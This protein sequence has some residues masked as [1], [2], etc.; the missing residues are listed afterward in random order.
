MN[1]DKKIDFD[2]IKNLDGIIFL[3]DFFDSPHDWG[4]LA[5]DDFYKWTIY[6][7]YLIQKY[8]LR[9]GVKPHPNSWHNSLDSVLI[10]Q[11]LKKKF[12]KIIWLD[13][14]YPNKA[15]F[16]NI[17]FGISCT[18]TVLFELA[19]HNIKAISC[20]DHPGIN[21]NFTINAKNKTEYKNILLNIQNI[22]IPDYSNNDL[23]IYNYLYNHI[24]MDAYSN[25]ARKLNLKEIDFR[26]SNSLNQFIDK[27]NYNDYV[28]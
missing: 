11:R 16:K 21:F 22:K 15:I 25:L 19:Y 12:P 24:N 26:N 9:I 4:N 13:K 5:F 17:N 23:L 18:G 7:L 10:Y 20:G 14:G 3:Q 27:M 1:N 8:N 2:L 6:S 28:H